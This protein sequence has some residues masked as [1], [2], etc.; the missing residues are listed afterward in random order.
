MRRDQFTREELEKGRT[1][2]PSPGAPVLGGQ[3]DEEP[4][5]QEAEEEPPVAF[6]RG[7][8][9]ISPARLNLL[10]SYS[11]VTFIFLMSSSL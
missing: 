2:V 11:S 1:E 7:E 8:A 9:G 10:S 4:P 6:L 5:E 3:R